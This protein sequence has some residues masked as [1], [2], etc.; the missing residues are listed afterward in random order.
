MWSRRTTRL[1]GHGRTSHLGHLH[2]LVALCLI[3]LSA[4]SMRIGNIPGV[5]TVTPTPSGPGTTIHV[6]IVH[7][8]GGA[9]L[10]L[11]PVTINNS[12][13]YSFAVDTGAS[14]SLIDRPLAQQLRLKQV[15]GPQAIAGIGSNEQAIPVQVSQWHAE[16]LTLPAEVL[17]SAELFASERGAGVQGLLGSDIWN[18]FGKITIDYAASTM[19]VY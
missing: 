18:Q 3:A 11:V 14:T 6:N 17:A 9:T 7:G 4:C 2:A 12:G 10:V 8:P 19:T 1:T 16:A 5:A 15:G 13:S